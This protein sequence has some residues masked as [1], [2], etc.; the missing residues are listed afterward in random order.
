MYILLNFAGYYYT[1]FEVKMQSIIHANFQNNI[2]VAIL[3]I[4][5]IIEQIQQMQEGMI[6]DRIIAFDVETPNHMNN[7]ICSIGLSVIENAEIV[8]SQYYL[9]DPCE[10]FDSFNVMLHGITPEAVAGAPDFG[11]LW[12]LIG[13][14]MTSGILCAHNAVFD[15]GVLK[16]LF[17][18]YGIYVPPM[19]YV[20][21]YRMTQKIFKSMP[22]HKLNTVCDC[23][24][25]CL[26][27][28]NAAS[29]SKAC[30]E[31]LC[32]L[33]KEGFPIEPHLRRVTFDIV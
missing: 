26:D 19:N 21:T 8:Q 23:M 31:I 22:N 20:C 4:S 33:L 17:R 30:A 1:S 12:T 27:H 14:V 24:G 15:L 32:K 18:S 9:V 3:T 5:A 28:H 11:E 2:F 7:T 10:E 29:D 25:I 16:K 13:P 6:M